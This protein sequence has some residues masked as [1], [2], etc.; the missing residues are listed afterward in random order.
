M[1]RLVLGLVTTLLMLG[2]GQGGNSS[3]VA[4]TKYVGNCPPLSTPGNAPGSI[5]AVVDQ[6]AATEI[7]TQGL[8]SLTV[9]IAKQG[10]PLYSQAYGYADDAKCRPAEVSTAYEIGS[11]TKQF[12]AAAI[13]QLE[14]RGQ[15]TIDSP[16]TLYLSD[17][18]FD[19]RITLR[20]L[21]NQTSG[22]Q[23]YLNLPQSVNWVRGVQERTVLNAIVAAP[24]V[25]APG[26]AYA[27]SNS[28][29]Y[30]LGAVIEAVSGTTYGEYLTAAILGPLGLQ[31]TSL[32]QPASSAEPYVSR[33]IADPSY[34]FS[35]GALWSNIIDLTAWDAAVS[36]GRV[37]DAAH[38]AEWMN[39]PR[40][41]TDY[42]TATPTDYAMGWVRDSLLGRT[43]LWHNG[44]TANFT[45]FNGV[46]PDDG[47][48][49]AILTNV[50]TQE[51]T[52]LLEFAKNVL[53]ATCTAQSGSC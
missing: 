51:D 53:Q 17:Y 18:A 31:S 11:V 37:L 6:M 47:L 48:S 25:F 39:P 22:L 29:Y 41:I 24:P 2:C 7:A 21:L 34:F 12:T 45:A 13:L 43:F 28:N 52:P 20:M 14:E 35:A 49:I 8:P 26:T 4:G 15:L 50:P 36:S 16:L 10:R 46:L 23:D 27:Y 33:A 44:E 19:P 42:Q 3:G 30:V 9:E 40:G 1:N 32:T 5:G 38:L